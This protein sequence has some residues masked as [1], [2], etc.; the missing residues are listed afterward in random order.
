MEGTDSFHTTMILTHLLFTT[1]LRGMQTEVCSCLG[2][3]L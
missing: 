1:L 2:L 3:Y